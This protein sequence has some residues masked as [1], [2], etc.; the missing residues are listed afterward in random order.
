[1]CDHR[2]FNATCKVA[3][4]EDS[5]RFLLEATVRCTDCGKPFQFLGLQPGLDFNG[6][7]VSIDGLELNIGICPEG[8]HPSPMASM[9]RGYDISLGN[10]GNN[11]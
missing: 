1:M 11:Q 9:L 6:A 7:R 10:S 2:N 8:A 3:R 5:G 4:M